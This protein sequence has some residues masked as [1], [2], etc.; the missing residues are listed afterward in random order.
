VEEQEGFPMNDVYTMHILH[1][2]PKPREDTAPEVSSQ[3]VK[4]LAQAYVPRQP[5]TEIFSPEEGLRR[6]TAFPNL[7]QP[8][9]GWQPR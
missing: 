1:T 2:Q 9:H 4:Q 8:Y 5:L 6:G 3:R 7:Y